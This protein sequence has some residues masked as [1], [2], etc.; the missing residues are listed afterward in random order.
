M[1]AL[2]TKVVGRVGLRADCTYQAPVPLAS[3]SDWLGLWL[4]RLTVAGG[5]GAM[6]NTSC[7]ARRSPLSVCR[8]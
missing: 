6:T 8:E 7:C 2:T 3:V 5:G 1:S 4:V